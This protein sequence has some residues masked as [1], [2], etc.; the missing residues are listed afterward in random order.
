MRV[1]V[2]DL[3][4]RSNRRNRSKRSKRSMIRDAERRQLTV[5]FCD[6]VGST[7]LSG[8][9]DPEDR[10]RGC[11]EAVAAAVAPFDSHV[12]QLLGDGCLVYVGCPNERGDDAEHAVHSA[13]RVQHAL[14]ALR[15]LR[16]GS[17]DRPED[18]FFGSSGQFVGDLRP[19]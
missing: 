14:A 16:A 13:L 8:R 17:E 5:M 2:E 10:S 19:F 1:A 3:L 11:H 4:I 6:P 15:A 12:A 9:L 7:Q 18:R